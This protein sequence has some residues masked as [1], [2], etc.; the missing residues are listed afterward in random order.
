MRDD[1]Y[2]DE[3]RVVMEPWTR[4]RNFP[5]PD[6]R[7]GG[8]RYM[9]LVSVEWSTFVAGGYATAQSAEAIERFFLNAR[10]LR[11]IVARVPRG[12]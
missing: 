7:Y 1:I 8:R 11:V 10:A 4:R 12:G 5:V 3:G 9:F 6:R 2:D